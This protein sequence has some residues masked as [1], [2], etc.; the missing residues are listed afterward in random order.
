MQCVTQP[1]FD[2]SLLT[3]EFFADPYPICYRLRSEAPVYWSDVMESWVLTRYND[4]NACLRDS[5]LF[6]NAGR[7]TALV[8]QLPKEQQR[9]MEAFKSHFEH[10]LMHSDPPIHTRLRGLVN[11]AFTPR[12]VESVREQVQAVTDRLLDGIQSKEGMDVIRDLAY[13]LPAMVISTF[14]GL[15]VKDLDRFKRWSDDI[16][17]VLG[18]GRADINKIASAQD[19]ILEMREYLGE[20]MAE[21]RQCPKED[22]LS[23]L[24]AAEEHGNKLTTAELLATVVTM[25]VAGH[26]TTTNLIGN[27]LLALLRHPDQLQQLRENPLLIT[28]TTEESLRYDSPLFRM[29]RI[30]AEDIEM[31]G[32]RLRKGDAVSPMIGAAN[33]DPDQFPNPDRFDIHRRENRH[34]AFGTGIHF[35]IGAPL[36]RLEGPIAI[37]TILRRFPKLRLADKAIEWQHNVTLRGLK[38]LHVVFG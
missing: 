2:Q 23:N 1:I 4:V 26:E 33:H 7:M 5:K 28:A 35:C 30:A 37:L 27:G 20:L 24:L 15:P 18:T 38:S 34:I 13:P 17:S 29:F 16:M 3:P 32:Q 11:K 6:S 10:G 36:A 14:L 19:S 9:Q 21:R 8:N 22:L 25:F 31:N 12:V